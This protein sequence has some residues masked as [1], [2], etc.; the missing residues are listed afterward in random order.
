[1]AALAERLPSVLEGTEPAGAAADA[2]DLASICYQR[3]LY[4][5]STRLWKSGMDQFEGLAADLARGCR[6]D[7]ACSAALAGCGKGDDSP[8]GEDARAALRKQALEWLRE[9]L[10]AR[11]A[12]E[13]APTPE[14]LASLPHWRED[15]DLAGVRDAA[16][17]EALPPG[18]RDAWKALWAEVDRAIAGARKG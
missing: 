12:T 3:R 5:G 13:V 9:D 1:M 11:M 4:A 18:E 16:A 15:S 2:A 7:A 17:L 6:Y 10:S 14:G 8:P